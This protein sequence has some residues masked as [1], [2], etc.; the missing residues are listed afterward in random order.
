M[1]AVRYLILPLDIID[2]YSFEK[3]A[4]VYLHRCLEFLLMLVTQILSAKNVTVDT[5]FKS[6]EVSVFLFYRIFLF[7]KNIKN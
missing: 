1:P 3:M 5:T 7:F 6:I 2:N 4:C